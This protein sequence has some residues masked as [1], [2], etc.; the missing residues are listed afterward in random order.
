MRDQSILYLDRV[1]LILIKL[2]K[3]GLEYKF[4]SKNN[5][6]KIFRTTKLISI[7][8]KDLI[9]EILMINLVLFLN[10]IFKNNK[11]YKYCKLKKIRILIFKNSQR[12][13]KLHRRT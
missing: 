7:N 6:W 1:M 10:K 3:W 9:K 8:K 11:G 12:I 5:H 2:L 13:L 4:S